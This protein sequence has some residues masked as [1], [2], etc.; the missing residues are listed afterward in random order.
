MASTRRPGS[1][2]GCGRRASRSVD[3]GAPGRKPGFE[4]ECAH[5]L[6]SS[7]CGSSRGAVVAFSTGTREQDLDPLFGLV[8]DGRALAA[9]FHPFLE[10]A[11]AVLKGRL[12][13]SRRSTSERRRDRMSSKRT[14]SVGS[15]AGLV[16]MIGIV[17][18]LAVARAR[19]LTR[20]SSCRDDSLLCGRGAIVEVAKGG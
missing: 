8:E 20:R 2:L 4:V 16:A 5:R 12:P 13:L 10:E 19:V 11:Q 1:S 17:A 6:S 18:S 9:Q 7:S 15:G 3:L 14:G